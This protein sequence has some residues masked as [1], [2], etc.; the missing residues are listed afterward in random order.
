M[1]KT[2]EMLAN[3]ICTKKSWNEKEMEMSLR[4]K[5]REAI[6]ILK[7]MTIYPYCTKDEIASIQHAKTEREVEIINLHLQKKY[8]DMAAR[9]NDVDPYDF[10]SSRDL[11]KQIV[12]CALTVKVKNDLL[13]LGINTLGDFMEKFVNHELSTD[14]I[15]RRVAN[16]I[17][18]MLFKTMN[19]I[20]YKNVMNAYFNKTEF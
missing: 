18:R 15:N 13:K 12:D 11:A 8:Y 7:D 6:V 19:E 1:N 17:T 2:T 9:D 5:K 10:V 20:Q 16:M 14:V 4:N 3:E